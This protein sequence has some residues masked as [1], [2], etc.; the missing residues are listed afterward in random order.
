[1]HNSYQFLDLA[2]SAV[3]SSATPVPAPAFEHGGDAGK[4]GPDG[5]LHVD[6]FQ[7][8]IIGAVL[9]IIATVIY[10]QIARFCQEY[11]QSRS[12]SRINTLADIEAQ[13][14]NGR[15]VCHME[16][17]NKYLFRKVFRED[18]GTSAEDS[19]GAA[20]SYNDSDQK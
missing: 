7:F 5:N 14:A 19:K 15:G 4:N 18:E 6:N 8:M 16:D 3:P 12:V 2:A 20:A 17:P 13:Q 1:M 9:G 10:Y 11:R